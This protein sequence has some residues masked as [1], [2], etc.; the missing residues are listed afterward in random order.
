MATLERAGLVEST[1]VGKWVHYKRN[2]GAFF[3][4]AQVLRGS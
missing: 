1:R 2:E 3:Q 4:L